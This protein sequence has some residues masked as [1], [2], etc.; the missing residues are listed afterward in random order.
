MSC[1]DVKTYLGPCSLHF[2]SVKTGA[3]RVVRPHT[4]SSLCVLCG[5]CEK[6][7][8]VDA[9]TVR[10]RKDEAPGL[11]LA[12]DFCKGCGIC[13]NVCPKD[14]VKMISEREAQNG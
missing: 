9:I 13:A 7:C 2:A 12:L 5:I 1:E 10:G 8:P 14:A 3:W 11:S 4:D 6:Y